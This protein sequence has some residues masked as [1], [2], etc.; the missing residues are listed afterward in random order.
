MRC[1][2]IAQNTHSYPELIY[3]QIAGT[4]NVGLDIFAMF[5]WYRE[6]EHEYYQ[7]HPTGKS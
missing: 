2:A 1:T 7:T 4:P 6:I 5:D 3:A